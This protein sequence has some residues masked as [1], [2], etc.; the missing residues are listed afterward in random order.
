MSFVGEKL[1][2]HHL[3][4]GTGPSALTMDGNHKAQVN[5]FGQRCWM[6]VPWF[7]LTDQGQLVEI[8]H[9]AIHTIP[10]QAF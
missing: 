4:Y 1:G 2:R 3:R 10:Q 6:K 9:G 7:F 8:I 5:S